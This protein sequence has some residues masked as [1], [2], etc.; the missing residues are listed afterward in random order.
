[1]AAQLV[2]RLRADLN[3]LKR[4][5]PLTQNHDEAPVAKG[6]RRPINL[7]LG[8]VGEVAS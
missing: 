3:P 4:R 2:L 1:M 6:H 8:Q 5:T 7:I